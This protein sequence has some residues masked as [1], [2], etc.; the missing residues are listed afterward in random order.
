M[1]NL[2]TRL[3]YKKCLLEET[4][5]EKKILVAM[6]SRHKKDKIVYD[7][8]KFDLEK[9]LTYN[10]KQLAIFLKEGKDNLES[11]DRS[12]NVYDKLALELERERM[13]REMHVN[14]LEAMIE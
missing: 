13:E 7:Q 4:A 11:K 12:T 1:G 9:E 14:N 5:T 8:R 2:K 10:R 6:E 3:E